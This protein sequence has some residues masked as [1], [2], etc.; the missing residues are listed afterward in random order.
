MFNSTDIELKK[1]LGK[2]DVMALIF[3]N[4]DRL[5]LGGFAC[6]MD[7]TSRDCRCVGGFSSHRRTLCVC[8]DCIL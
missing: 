5:D 1:V 7:W 4:Y 2:R 3:W 6:I 8:R